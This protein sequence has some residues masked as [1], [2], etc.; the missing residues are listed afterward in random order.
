MRL[1]GFSALI[2]AGSSVLLAATPMPAPAATIVRN[3]DRVVLTGP[4]QP[5][6]DT[7]FAAAVDDDVKM[8]VLGSDGGHVNEAMA[9]GRLIRRRHLDTAVPSSCVSACVLIWAAGDRRTVDGVLRVHCPT[10]INSPY[11]CDA[12]ERQRM[13]GYLT[14]M[15]APA[16]LV[17]MQEAVN[18]MA[19]QVTPEQLAEAPEARPEVADGHGE[20]DDLDDPPP[21]R[22]PRPVPYYGPPPGWIVVPTEQRAMPCL[23]TL[24]TFGALRFCI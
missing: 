18:W 12:P 11:Q 7:A 1:V 8:V 9:I 14:Q 19:L 22:R 3:G 10:R 5:G 23:P 20:R 17:R 15:N 2:L 24:L 16:G 4:I 21:R 13:V 6:D